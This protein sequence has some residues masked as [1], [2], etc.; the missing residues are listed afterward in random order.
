MKPGNQKL[1]IGLAA[2]AAVCIA[3]LLF[4][5]CRALERPVTGEATAP[6]TASGEAA[7]ILPPP[8]PQPS[9]ADSAKKRQ[10]YFHRDTRLAKILPGEGLITN[11]PDVP[12]PAASTYQIQSDRLSPDETRMAFGQAVVRKTDAGLFGTWPPDSI[13]VRNITT[14]DPGELLIKMEGAEIHNFIWS[15]DG[16]KL[17]FTSWEPTGIRNWVVD[18]TTKKVQEVKLPTYYT[19]DGKAH[20]MSLAAWSPD[21]QWFAVAD[22]GRLYL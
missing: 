11:F 10:I 1:T 6:R 20:S 7:A 14:T 17:A 16:K 21:G 13:Y 22:E 12:F 15:P 19:P 9:A 4:R 8:A 18:A 5:G 3:A 2:V